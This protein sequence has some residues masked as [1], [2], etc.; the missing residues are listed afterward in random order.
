[1]PAQRPRALPAA[2]SRLSLATVLARAG[3]APQPHVARPPRHTPSAPSC[4]PAAPQRPIALILPISILT[5]ASCGS[6]TRAPAT[7]VLAQYSVNE[8]SIRYSSTGV[9]DCAGLPRQR[10]ER[11]LTIPFCEECF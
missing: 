5:C 3:A 8:H 9:A 1:M 2:P 11:P 6:V 4:A 7:H 10:L